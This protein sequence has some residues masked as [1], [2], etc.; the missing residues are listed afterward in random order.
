MDSFIVSQTLGIERCIERTDTVD[1]KSVTVLQ[2]QGVNLAVR[3]GYCRWREKKDS[4]QA[5]YKHSDVLDVNT[6]YTNDLN[7]ILNTY[8]VEACSRAI[9]NVSSFALYLFLARQIRAGR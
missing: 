7:L 4:L 2:T 8:G 9:V 3:E 1:G 5:L 6:L